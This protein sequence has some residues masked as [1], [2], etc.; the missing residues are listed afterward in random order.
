MDVSGTTL[1][2]MET[3]G[4]QSPV[5]PPRKPERIS[6]L[7]ARVLLSLLVSRSVFLGSLI[8]TIWM[9]VRNK[10]S[11]LRVRDDGRRGEWKVK[12]VA[13]FGRTTAPS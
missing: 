3:L 4:R 1:S 5:S 8:I 13:T 7:V 12:P 11:G 6:C 2:Q 10:W 9:F